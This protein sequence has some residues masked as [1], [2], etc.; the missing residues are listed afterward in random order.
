MTAAVLTAIGGGTMVAESA[1]RTVIKGERAGE[2]TGAVVVQI[3]DR[4][5]Q[6]LIVRQAI[7]AMMVPG[8]RRTGRN[9]RCEEHNG[10]G[11]KPGPVHVKSPEMPIGRPD[12]NGFGG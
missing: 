3:A 12:S 6:P 7:I 1:R 5:W 9:S 10:G 8:F 2:G 11:E 4:V